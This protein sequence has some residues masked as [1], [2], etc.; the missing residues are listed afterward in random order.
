MAEDDSGDKTEAPT[1]RRRQEAREQ[2]NVAKSVDLSAAAVMIGSMLLLRSYGINVILALRVFLQQMLTFGRSDAA[3]A[4]LLYDFVRGIAMVG[5]ALAPIFIGLIVI[6]ILSNVL[7]TGLIFNPGRLTP[8]FAG[9]NPFKGFGKLFGGGR[10]PMSVLMNIF[11]LL[12]VAVLSYSAIHQRLGLIVLAQQLNYLQIFQLGAQTIFDVALR[13]GIALFVLAIIDYAYQR[14][15]IEQG[16]KMSK[17]EIKEEMRRMEGDPLMKQRRRQIAVQ[18]AHKKLR[19]DVPKADVI[20]TNPTHYAIALQY[21]SKTMRAP[22]VIA[23]GGDFMAMRIREIAAEHGIPILERAPL[24][25]A[26][27]KLC[28]IG[29]PIPAEFYSA[30]AEI[31]AYVYELTGK[32]KKGRLQPA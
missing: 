20:V 25:R 27:F 4:E 31:L 19:K 11:K 8:N 12:L 16:L 22:I 26:L 14:Y 30:V 15:Q 13:V 17:Q 1:P 7:Q 10:G 18:I 29:D 5:A 24:A 9:L 23:K 2:G 6:A 28:D 21:D 32:M 3:P